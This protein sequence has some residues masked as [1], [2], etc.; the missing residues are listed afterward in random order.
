MNNEKYIDV[1]AGCVDVSTKDRPIIGTTSLA[2][3]VGFV[4]YDRDNMKA[5]AGHCFPDIAYDK[6]SYTNFY[7]SICEIL[8]SNELLSHKF[9]LI[10]VEGAYTTDRVMEAIYKLLTDLPIVIT[11]IKSDK[12]IKNASCAFSDTDDSMLPNDIAASRCFAF[13]SISGKF[14]TK[15]M[16]FKFKK[17]WN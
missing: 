11:E 7:Y 17:I 9:E 6:T 14:V 10:L 8:L 13:D 16:N 3:C 1:L 2:S 15:Q 4:L 12:T 5:I